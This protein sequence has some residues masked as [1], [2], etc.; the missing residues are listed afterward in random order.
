M[1]VEA[2]AARAALQVAQ[3]AGA[4]MAGAIESTAAAARERAA[5]RRTLQTAMAGPVSTARMVVLLPLL[6]PLLAFALGMNPIEAL[7]SGPL[8]PA[9]VLIGALLMIAAWLWSRRII[10]AGSITDGAAGLELELLGIALG[11]GMSLEAARALVAD[12][13]SAAELEPAPE[14]VVDEI[15]TLAQRA[16]VPVRGLLESEARARRHAAGQ[17]AE[18]RAAKAAVA[19]TIPLGVCVLPAFVLLG[20]VPF[21]LTTLQGLQLPL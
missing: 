4:G 11:G 6:G 5:L 19:L 2:R 1:P 20:V 16:G 8:G 13:L 10:T 15:T 18:R 14:A 9:A 3:R 12:A 17:E 21:V 7:T